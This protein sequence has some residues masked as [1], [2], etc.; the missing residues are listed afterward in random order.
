MSPWAAPIVLLKKKDGS[1]RLCVNYR[2]LN[3][4]THNDTYPLPR[5]KESL[6]GLK[7]AKWYST[8]DLASS[9]C[10]VEMDPPVRLPVRQR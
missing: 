5:M 8:L 9:C 3:A 7:A 4:L 2:R 10:Q 1:L 6:T